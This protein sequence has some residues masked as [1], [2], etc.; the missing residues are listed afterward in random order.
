M[1]TEIETEN[2]AAPVTLI[3]DG[4]EVSPCPFCGEAEDLAVVPRMYHGGAVEIRGE[5]F[6]RVEC[7]PCDARTGDCFDGD[8]KDLG[9]ASGREMAIAQWN[10]R[11]AGSQP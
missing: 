2:T 1:S 10:R 8:A 11:V 5:K 6:W 4:I 9:F 3:I 7:L